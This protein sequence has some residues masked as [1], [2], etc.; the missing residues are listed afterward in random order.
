MSCL[1]DTK[2]PGGEVN[3]MVTRLYPGRELPQFPVLA[4][5][6]RE[7]WTLELKITRVLSCFNSVQPFVTLWT[8]ARQAPLSMRFSRQEYWSGLPFPTPG[9]LPNSGIK[10]ASLISPALADR[11]FTTSP[12]WEAPRNWRLTVPK[13]TKMLL[14]RPLMKELKINCT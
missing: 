14:V 13:T 7:K 2:T 6:K 4:T 12:I 11:F 3:Y 10:C 9:D 1:I 5:K 8:V